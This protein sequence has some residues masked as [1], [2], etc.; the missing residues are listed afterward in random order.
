MSQISY[1]TFLLRLREIAK[2]AL[3]NY[4]LEQI[5]PKFVNYSGNGLYQVIVPPRSSIPSGKYAL[6][7]HQP[8]YMKPEFIVS[9]MQWLSA[10]V[11]EGISVPT[12]IRNKEGDW[13]SVIDGGY[14]IPAKRNCTLL[15]WTEG[16]LL[17]Q[18]IRPKHFY[19]LGKVIGRIHKQARTWKPP[20]GFARPHWDWE[21]LFGDGFDYGVPA[22]TVREA[23]PKKHQE[24]FKEVIGRVHEVEELLGKNRE[25]YGLIHADLAFGD[26]V[27]IQSGE[28]VPFDFDDCG[29]GFW[30]YDLSVALAHFILDTGNFSSVMHDALIKGYEDVNTIEKESLKYLNLF[31]AARF[32]QLMFFF[33]G[34]IIRYPQSKTEGMSEIKSNAKY[35]KL[36]LK[37]MNK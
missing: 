22:E 16:R 5:R 28:A 37:R 25:V 8:N 27:A 2:I 30:M 9:E 32:A 17:R 18:S 1:R 35:L 31:I 19:S 29:F 10:L 15:S 4:G 12:P 21:G 3:E 6:R 20:Q 33:Q 11:D 26:N 13:L 14:E 24:A 7:I 36:L 34:A 23:I